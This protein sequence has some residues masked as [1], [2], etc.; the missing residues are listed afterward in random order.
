MA[1]VEERTG[2]P[3]VGA[4]SIRKGAIAGIVAT[5]AVL[6]FMIVVY[7]RFGIYANAALAFNI[8][9]IVAIM[10]MFNATLTL[11]GIAG[12]VLTIGAAVD[13]NELG[14]AA[15]RERVCPSV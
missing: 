8:A 7:G 11:P 13:A 4:D 1:V 3:E 2:T 15:C 6:V 5:V 10:G 14:R 9:L 12:F